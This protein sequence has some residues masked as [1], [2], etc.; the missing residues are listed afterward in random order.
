MELCRI[1]N[2]TYFV[3]ESALWDPVHN[4][5][6]YVDIFEGKLYSY[7]PETKTIIK[8]DFDCIVSACVLNQKDELVLVT[9]RGIGIY[10]P[11]TR[12]FTL[13]C[14]PNKADEQ[15]TRYNDCKCDPKGRL[16]AG[17]I[18]LNCRPG[19]GKL[20]LINPDWSYKTVMEGVDY[21][22]GIVWID[23]FMLY[24]DTLSGNVYRFHYELENGIFSDKTLLLTLPAGEPD[25]MAADSDGNLWIAR[26]GGH[27][28]VCVDIMTGEILRK[29]ELP[30]INVSSI[31]FGRHDGAEVLITTAKKDLSEED[32]NAYPEC[33]SV[34]IGSIDAKGPQFY[35]MKV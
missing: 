22:N 8:H 14:H 30:V 4:C 7:N 33:G 25:G 11:D 24:T 23:S 27:S 2:E 5:Y 29:I 6:Y 17:T 20:Y 9:Q 31:A 12:N 34:Y 15:I 21:S 28:L 26:W 35:K 19:F 3:G 16:F 13:K 32:L 1:S 18:D 10:D